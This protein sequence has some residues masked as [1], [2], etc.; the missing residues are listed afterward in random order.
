MDTWPA[1]PS[2][3]QM[4]VKAACVFFWYCHPILAW[5]CEFLINIRPI[6][7]GIAACAFVAQ[8]HS[9]RSIGFTGTCS[10]RAGCESHH[11]VY[12]RVLTV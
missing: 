6:A 12:V 10:L 4:H 8:V 5:D 1:L 9:E 11:H 7:G 3:T 2:A